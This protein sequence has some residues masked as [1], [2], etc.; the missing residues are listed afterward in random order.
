MAGSLQCVDS[1]QEGWALE[2]QRNTNQGPGADQS[3]GNCGVQDEV[4]SGTLS[5][6]QVGAV[7]S[8]GTT[9]SG[10]VAGLAHP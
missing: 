2:G 5:P 3:A 9:Y 6:D 10:S 8:L 4:A 7:R 1:C